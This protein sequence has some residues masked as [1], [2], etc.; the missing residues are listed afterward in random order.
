MADWKEIK[1]TAR[2]VAKGTV[3]K[4][5]ELAESATLQLKLTAAKSKRDAAYEKLGRLTYKQLKNGEN[6]A[7]AI[8]KVVEEID[9]AA[10]DVERL[11]NKIEASKAK[12]A[13]QKQER[14]EAKKEAEKQA[15]EACA[16]NV[17]QVIS[18]NSEA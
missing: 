2:R 16:E 7:E 4:T 15:D 6:Q 13:Q 9:N 12:K 11:K 17:R 10:A 18:E 3:R 5:E 8:S 14:K 1:D